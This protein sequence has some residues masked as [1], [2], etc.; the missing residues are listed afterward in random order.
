MQLARAK[1]IGEMIV[2][3]PVHRPVGP[4]A[5][6]RKERVDGDRSDYDQCECECDANAPQRPCKEIPSRRCRHGSRYF[7]SLVFERGLQDI[8][9]EAKLT[10]PS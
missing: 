3:A 4:S 1:S 10:M 8:G 5:G 7:T 6:A 2:I 9:G